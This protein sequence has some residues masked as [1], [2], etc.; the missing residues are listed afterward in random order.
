MEL[1]V[2][3]IKHKFRNYIF[4]VLLWWWSKV[5]SFWNANSPFMYSERA[6]HC[7][8]N[9]RSLLIPKNTNLHSIQLLGKFKPALTQL[10]WRRRNLCISSIVDLQGRNQQRD[11]W[12]TLCKRYLKQKKQLNIAQN[13]V[14]RT[15]LLNYTDII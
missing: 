2:A 1:R 6:K 15:H 13:L 4:K 8:Q 12:L 10:G 5:K 7:I 3:V 14:Q 9:M 11:Q